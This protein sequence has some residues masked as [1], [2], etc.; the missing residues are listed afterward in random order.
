MSVAAKRALVKAFFGKPH[1]VVVGAST[2]RDK[3]GNKVGAIR[4]RQA[5]VHGKSPALLG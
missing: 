3:F 5:A 1:F 4:S 2:N